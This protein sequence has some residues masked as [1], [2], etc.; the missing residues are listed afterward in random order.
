[1]AVPTCVAVSRAAYSSRP[2]LRPSGKD[3]QGAEQRKLQLGLGARCQ[4]IAAFQGQS[5]CSELG[6]HGARPLASCRAS[7]S[8]SETI[9]Y[10]PCIS[11]DPNAGGRTK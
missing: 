7:V 1:M 11:I 3:C 2:G 4:G 8:T 10:Q 9:N 6:R 5:L